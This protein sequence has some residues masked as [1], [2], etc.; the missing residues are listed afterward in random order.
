MAGASIFRRWGVRLWM[1]YVDDISVEINYPFEVESLG[2]QGRN[3]NKKKIQPYLLLVRC[4][5]QP[6]EALELEFN[7]NVS[8]V[9]M[10]MFPMY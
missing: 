8:I 9:R 3:V 5:G 10:E 7:K 6:E 2:W 4:F 1:R